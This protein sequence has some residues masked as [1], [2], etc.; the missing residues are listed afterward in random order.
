[1]F[2]NLQSELEW[3]FSLN[4]LEL[5][6]YSTIQWVLELELE[7]EFRLLMGLELELELKNRN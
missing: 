2:K 4:E 3:E 1:M 5:N 7:L 6:W